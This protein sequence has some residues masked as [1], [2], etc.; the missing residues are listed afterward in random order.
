MQSKCLISKWIFGLIWKDYWINGV[1]EGWSNIAFFYLKRFE[2]S[3]PSLQY[4]NNPFLLLMTC[5]LI[6]NNL[7]LGKSNELWI[8][9]RNRIQ[10]FATAHTL[11]ESMVFVAIVWPIIVVMVNCRPVIFQKIL[12]VDTIGRL[13]IL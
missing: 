11:A 13:I 5:M 4:S 8:V 3:N 10:S 12:S 7:L 6:T 1:M 9:R 2:T